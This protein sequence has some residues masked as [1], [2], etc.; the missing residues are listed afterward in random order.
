M[1]LYLKSLF[2]NKQIQKQIE[3]LFQKILQIQIQ[4]HKKK[5][6]IQIFF[7]YTSL[8]MSVNSLFDYVYV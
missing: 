3:I 7:K 2:F 8:C 5:F 4:I 1:Y 6:K